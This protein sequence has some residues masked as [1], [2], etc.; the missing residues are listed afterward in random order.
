MCISEPTLKMVVA[1][2]FN[3]RPD[4]NLKSSSIHI[5]FC[6]D[7]NDPPIAN[8]SSSAN[9]VRLYSFPFIFIPVI[10]RSFKIFVD[11]IS[12]HKKE[13]LR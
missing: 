11:E 5:S 2:T 9:I 7:F 6:K 4:I 12:M 8:V 13:V 10:S 1:F 3:F